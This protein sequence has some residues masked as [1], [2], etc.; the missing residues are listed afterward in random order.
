[1]SD[2]KKKILEM[3]DKK[4]ITAEEAY[5]LLSAVD[6]KEGEH[7]DTGTRESRG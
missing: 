1:M 4:K 7:E 3:L 6:S 5:R 2:S